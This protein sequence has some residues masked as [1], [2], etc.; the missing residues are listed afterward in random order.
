VLTLCLTCM[1]LALASYFF[2]YCNFY[3]MLINVGSVQIIN[4]QTN[5]H[6]SSDRSA[7]S[8]YMT[9]VT[10]VSAPPRRTSCRFDVL[11][12]DNDYTYIYIYIYIYI[13][14]ALLANSIYH[15]LNE[16]VVFS[17]VHRRVGRQPE[18]DMLESWT[19]S[20]PVMIEVWNND[21]ASTI[22][23]TS[24]WRAWQYWRSCFT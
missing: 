14:N 22:C 23:L 3:W 8:H 7:V 1:F 5:N 10:D 13:Y 21:V 19:G 11:W 15:L 9:A 2:I 16:L 4:K 17:V 24:G 18:R 20:E 6:S 12:F